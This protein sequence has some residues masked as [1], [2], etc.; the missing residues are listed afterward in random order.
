MA[1]AR[2]TR[3]W[4][5]GRTLERPRRPTARPVRPRKPPRFTDEQ[6][7][8]VRQRYAAGGVTQ[9]VLAAELGITRQACGRIIRGLRWA[10]V[11]DPTTH[12]KSPGDAGTVQT[13]K[14]P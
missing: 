6:I 10:H 1:E 8:R 11:I 14:E 7:I 4:H 12:T 9:A 3:P 13:S 5:F 2:D